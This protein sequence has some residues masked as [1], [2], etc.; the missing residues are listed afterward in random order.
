MV[1][2]IL[3][4]IV[5]LILILILIPPPGNA[6]AASPGGRWQDLIALQDYKVTQRLVLVFAE[7]SGVEVD[8]AVVQEAFDE[9]L[10]SAP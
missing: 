8:P 3:I 5:I 2:F 6:N 10:Y 9:L 4:L 7:A 1:M